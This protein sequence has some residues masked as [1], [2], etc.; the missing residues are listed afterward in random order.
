[1]NKKTL[2]VG[3]L[4]GALAGAALAAALA[5]RKTGDV[6]RGDS[7]AVPPELEAIVNAA[8]SSGELP[9]DEE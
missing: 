7:S 6:E 2:V 8:R 5:P 1:M 9:L 4:G 3:A